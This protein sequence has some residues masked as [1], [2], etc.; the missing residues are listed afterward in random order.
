[1]GDPLSAIDLYVSSIDVTFDKFK[2][3]DMDVADTLVGRYWEAVGE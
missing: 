3:R 2:I 1:M